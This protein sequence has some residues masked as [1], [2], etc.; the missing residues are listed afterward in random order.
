MARKAQEMKL[1][2]NLSEQRSKEVSIKSHK[3]TNRIS[4]ILGNEIISSDDE[5]KDSRD[6]ARTRMQYDLQD[7][8]MAQVTS[9]SITDGHHRVRKT[10]HKSEGSNSIE[11]CK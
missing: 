4:Y 8:T 6:G 1:T 5:E 3:K 10:K 9:T 2:L 7:F 11:N